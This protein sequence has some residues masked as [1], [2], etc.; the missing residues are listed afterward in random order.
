MGLQAFFRRLAGAALSSQGFAVRELG[1]RESGLLGLGGGLRLLQ[2]TAGGAMR[3]PF[4]FQ[5]G[6]QFSDARLEDCR[7]ITVAPAVQDDHRNSAILHEAVAWTCLI[8]T[9][10][11]SLAGRA[12]Q[13]QGTTHS[14]FSRLC[15]A[16]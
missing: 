5:R 6:V 16:R 2:R 10:L 12:L 7:G 4:C 14:V 1:V 15:V 8:S 3:G 13:T 11:G 9:L